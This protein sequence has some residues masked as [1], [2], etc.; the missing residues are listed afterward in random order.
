MQDDGTLACLSIPRDENNKHF[1]CEEITQQKLTNLTFFLIDFI[2]GVDT[3]YGKDRMAWIC[4][5]YVL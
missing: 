1:N 4:Q 5:A 3:K 2:D